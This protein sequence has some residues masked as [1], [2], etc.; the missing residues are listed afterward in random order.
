MSSNFEYRYVSLTPEHTAV[1]GL[2]T[3]GTHSA[4]AG[5]EVFGEVDDESF[6]HMF[7]LLTRS[8]MTRYGVSKSINGKEYSEGGIN[9]VAQPD[10]FLGMCL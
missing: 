8:D 6:A 4:T 3:Y 9:L 2:R 7:D 5:A 1:T 10:D